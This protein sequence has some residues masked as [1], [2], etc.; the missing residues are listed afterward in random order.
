[1]K[2][3]T[4]EVRNL[5]VFYGSEVEAVKSVSFHLAKGGSLGIIG[6]SGSGKTSIAMA[7]SALLQ[8]ASHVEGEILYKGV[9][10]QK[11]SAQERNQYRWSKIAM[12]FQNRLDILNP[13]LNIKEQIKESLKIHTNLL[14]KEIENKIKELFTMVGL[15][16]IWMQSYPHELSGGMRQKVLIAMALSC[17]P[18][19]LI[20]DEPT[21]SLDTVAKSE[22]IKLLKEL[23]KKNKFSMIVISHEISLIHAL[24][25]NMLVLYKG[26]ILEEG[27]TKEVIKN[28]IHPFTR[29][30]INASPEINPYQDLWG[31]RASRQE[32]NEKGCPF[33]E[34]CNQSINVCTD[35]LPILDY[36]SMERKVACNRGG[37]VT[38]LEAK[39]INKS[40][41]V[42]N[43]KVRACKDC[44]IHVKSG[45]IVSLIGQSGSGKTTFAS[46]LS[47]LLNPESGEILFE[48]KRVQNN[49]MVKQK[50]GIQMVFQDPFSSINE[51]FTIEDAVKEPLTILK[52]GTKEEQR[53][54]A[55]KV[56]NYVQMPCDED[57][58]NER[59]SALSG[60]QRQRI[61]IA[62]SLSMEP[63]LL[64]ADEISSMLD[65]STKANIL[66]LLKG[67]QN[68]MGFS[69]LYIT[70]DLTLARKISDRIYVMDKGEIVENGVSLDI[71]NHPKSMYTKKLITKGLHECIY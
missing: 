48:D 19:I 46:I 36:V 50:K 3:S 58:L 55:K 26:Y 15:D 62:R 12:V 40:Y 66:R 35:K 71:F 44:S 17:D 61:A 30:I 33:Y 37:I 4:L 27:L 31:I 1:M 24:T 65:P 5:S 49:D 29:G 8:D 51:H 67:L 52:I 25:A 38:L 22:I 13:V 6:E 7:I 57:F 64:I 63:K 39:N 14:K 16:E 11:L 47:G 53:E 41:K 32:H 45:E 43:R 18:E 68:Q 9:D 2:N 34:R 23:Q 21:S 42:K 20:V 54:I 56:L 69:M 70:H 60:G 28:P 59:C 10:L